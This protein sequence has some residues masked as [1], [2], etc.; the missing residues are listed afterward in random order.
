[1]PQTLCLYFEIFQIN[2]KL[3]YCLFIS[4]FKYFELS[5][6]YYT[7]EM[8]NALIINSKIEL[9]MRYKINLIL[10]EHK[11]SV[12]FAK[13]VKERKWIRQNNQIFFVEYFKYRLQSL[14]HV[15]VIE[16]VPFIP[17]IKGLVLFATKYQ[18]FDTISFQQLRF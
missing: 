18:T 10:T 13:I 7:L 14:S 11:K 12:H 1:M 5:P 8:I 9:E 6:F 16:E 15:Y 17:S 4:K 2:N 3:K